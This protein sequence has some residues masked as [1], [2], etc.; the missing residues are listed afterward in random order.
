MPTDP[1]AP[2]D[3]KRGR[4]VELTLE[5][6]AD[7][8]KSLARVGEGDGGFV[9]FVA[10]AVPGD[11]VRARVFKRKRGFAEA[12]LLEVLEASDL[13][14]TPRCEYAAAC[15]GCKWQH[16]EY[17]AQLAM[18][19]EQAV[20]ALTRARLDLG[21]ADVRPP[22]GAGDYDGSG[23]VFFYRNKM[24]F[25]FSA[26]RWLTDWE[27]ATGE[28]MDTDFA[29]GLHVPG[30]F[31]KV[32]D[33]KACY[34][35]SEWSARLVNGVRAFAK[36]HGWTPWHPREHTGYLRILAIRQSAHT[37]D[38][39][40]N[41]VTSHHDE[42][43]MAALADWL[44]A[45]FPE[46]TTLVNT[47][48]SGV[49]QTA[50]GEAVHTVFGPGLIRDRIGPH[51]FEIASNAFFQTNTVAAEGLYAVAREFA[52][53]R[54]S[55][56]VYDLY[57][58]FPDAALGTEATVPTLRGRAK[59]QIDPGIQSGRVLRMRGRGLPEVGGGRR[60]DQLVRVHVWTPEQV[61]GPLREALE[62]LRLEPDLKPAPG[63]RDKKGFF[64]RV[65]DAFTG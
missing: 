26:M 57:L 15:G 20:S 32:L 18:K 1:L 35:Q 36:E 59:L 27:I 61:S 6:F 51:T 29:L 21:A 24:E 19:G 10:G 7:R 48:N 23:G 44:R 65:K 14:T 60:G 38:R 56:V 40:V 49:A 33:L 45:E 5:A 39:M 28:E 43:R 58:S 13:R 63:A 16:V 62:Q 17:P 53:L 31:D 64:G 50:F 8:G 55:D 41:L 54:P 3:L 52:N 42:A 25:S 9:V 2:S 22:L 47:I 46:T 4:E 37:E 12:R 34:L 11:R 30:R